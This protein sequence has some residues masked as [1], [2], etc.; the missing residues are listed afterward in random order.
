MEIMEKVKVKRKKVRASDIQE[1]I[2]RIKENMN[3][4]NDEINRK[5]DAIKA[6]EDKNSGYGREEYT[7]KMSELAELRDAYGGLQEELEKEYTI[8]KKYK[9]SKFYI[10]PKDLITIVGVSGLAVFMI[11]LERENPKA[12][13]LASFILKLFPMKL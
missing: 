7:Q 9:D 3:W 5:I 6:I 4:L 12:T 8:L 13:K 11:A 1:N 2:L 10:Q